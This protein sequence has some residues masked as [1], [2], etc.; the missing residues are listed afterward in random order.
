MPAALPG[1]AN[2]RT[3]RAFSGPTPA[4]APLST[5]HMLARHTPLRAAAPS[6]AA[7][8]FPSC[9]PVAR[10]APTAASPR[11]TPRHAPR[12]RPAAAAATPCSGPLPSESDVVI[13]GAGLAGLH[14]TD[15]LQKANVTALLLEAS[16]GV[17][18]RV[19]TDEVDGFLLDRGFQ[20]FLTG[21]PYARQVLDFGALNLKPFYAGARV[22]YSGGWH[23]VADPLRH[24][25]DGLL[26]LGNPIGSVGDKVNVGVF[27]LKSLLGSIEDI[28]A[29]PETSIQQRLKVRGVWRGGGGVSDGA[30]VG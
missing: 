30:T 10:S 23:T 3:M 8:A 9:P 11:T 6:A 29:Q 19:R 16:D 24:F 18:G 2:M 7:A 20:I 15:L 4:P 5:R 12:T 21:Y 22:R 25:V 14:A 1:S 26:S 17:G 13:I 27:R 28:Y